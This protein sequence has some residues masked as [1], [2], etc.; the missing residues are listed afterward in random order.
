MVNKLRLVRNRKREGFP[1]ERSLV[2]RIRT[3]PFQ[4]ETG[5]REGVCVSKN[6]NNKK[7]LPDHFP[8]HSPLQ[9]HE[10]KV[11]CASREGC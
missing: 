2:V 6:R 5:L 3:V 9:K 10:G 7:M 8:L 1:C 4:T 11:L